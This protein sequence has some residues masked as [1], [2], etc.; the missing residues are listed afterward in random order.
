M[1]D[2][3]QLMD[4]GEQAGDE[5]VQKAVM[6]NLERFVP[7]PARMVQSGGRLPTHIRPATLV[8]EERDIGVAGK[9]I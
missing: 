9:R 5:N 3:P 4:A 1:S 2:R 8:D 6:P 7:K